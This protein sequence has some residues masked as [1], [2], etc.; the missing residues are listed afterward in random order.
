M[1]TTANRHSLLTVKEA[2]ARL[3]LHPM[4]VRRMIRDGRIPAVQLGGPGS[5]IRVAADELER[6]LAAHGHR[7]GTS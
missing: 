7:R 4:T 6:F 1:L 3:R 5:S 2:A